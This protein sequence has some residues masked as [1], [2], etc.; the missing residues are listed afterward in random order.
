MQASCTLA[1]LVFP[2]AA[3]NS[4]NHLTSLR[5]RHSTSLSPSYATALRSVTY[6]GAY[7]G[8]TLGLAVSIMAQ[9]L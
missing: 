4:D 5:D 8:T 2:K 7:A 3:K 6:L 9:S 1:G